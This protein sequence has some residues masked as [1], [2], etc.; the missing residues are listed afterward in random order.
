MASNGFSPQQAAIETSRLL[1]NWKSDARHL[2]GVIHRRF[3]RCGLQLRACMSEV[4]VG[5]ECHNGS[6]SGLVHIAF[7]ISGCNAFVS[8]EVLDDGEWLVAIYRFLR[9]AAGLGTTRRYLSRPR[10]RGR[11]NVA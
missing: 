4:E 5:D 3:L 8:G 11:E 10:S 7:W 9:S 6:C 1:E 2:D